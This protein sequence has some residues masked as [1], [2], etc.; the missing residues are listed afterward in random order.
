[1]TDADV[2]GAHIRTLLL[3]LFYRHMRPLIER[4]YVYAARPPLYR[5]RCGSETYEAMTEASRDRI[6]RA[7]GGWGEPPEP[8]A[9]DDDTTEREFTVE[10]NGKRFEVNL[11]ERG[12]QRYRRSTSPAAGRAPPGTAG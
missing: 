4:G 1:M 10:V 6:D 2:D 12:A 3:T 8:A 11:E 7:V 9:D 5:I